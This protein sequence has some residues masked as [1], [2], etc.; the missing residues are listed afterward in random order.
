MA[1]VKTAA[2][3]ETIKSRKLTQADMNAVEKRLALSGGSLFIEFS[4]DLANRNGTWQDEEKKLRDQ[5]AVKSLK[6][7]RVDYHATDEEKAEVTELRRKI[8]DEI[9]ALRK[10]E[11]SEYH[12]GVEEYFISEYGDEIRKEG[13]LVGYGER[14]YIDKRRHYKKY[15]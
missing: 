12:K 9:P 10:R 11:S 7:E 5:I 8:R 6:F 3:K 15:W 1:D 14:I 4:A 13:L 2:K